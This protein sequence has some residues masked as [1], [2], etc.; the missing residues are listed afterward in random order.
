MPKAILVLEDGTVIAGKGFGAEKEIFGEIVFNTSMTGY[1]EAF[2][3]PSYAGQILV[4]TYPLVGNYGFHLKLCE[5]SSVKIRGLVIKEPAFFSSRGKRIDKYLSEAGIPGIW[6]IDTRAITLKLRYYGT[7]K[8]ALIFTAKEIDAKALIK[9]IRK[10]PH[11]DIENLVK[12]VS[13]KR[14]I[15]HRNSQEKD[16]LAR[17]RRKAKHHHK[18]IEI[19]SGHSSSLRHK[20]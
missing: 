17:L 3:D 11:P 5:S 18:F 9:K 7:M 4:L 15:D 6:G 19:C 14:I 16:H 2:T 12:K 10:N 1:Q 13:C 8:A 20:L